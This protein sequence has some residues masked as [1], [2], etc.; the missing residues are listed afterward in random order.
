MANARDIKPDQLRILIVAEAGRHKTYFC[1]T[2]PGVYIFDTDD[3]M[4]VARGRDVEYD[5]FSEAPKGMKP[6]F[7]QH[8]WGKSWPE[9]HKKLNEIG[10]RLEKGI[11]PKAI[12][13]DSLTT[14]STVITN[15]ALLSEGKGLEMP[16]QGTWGTHHNLLK[17]VLGQLM[18]W[19]V[20]YIM[21]AHIQ[22]DEN[23]LTKMVEKLPLVAGKAAGFLPSYF[24]EVYY[25][26]RKTEKDGTVRYPITTGAT[27]TIVSAKSRWGV[28]DGTELD[29]GA[30]SEYFRKAGFAV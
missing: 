9:I 3:G 30:L 11:G 17:L 16:H 1:S 8:A 28:P 24:D 18:S 29:W 23:D 4:A 25:V 10:D 21:T 26:D 27:P 19:P 6:R 12:A 15:W 5:L 22:R 13:M 14:L 7:G 20:H 2:I